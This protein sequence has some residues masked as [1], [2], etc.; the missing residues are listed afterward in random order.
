MADHSDIGALLGLSM[1]VDPDPVETRE[2]LDGLAGVL[3]REGPVRAAYLLRRLTE[4]A[5]GLGVD[6]PRAL[7]TPYVN[8][9]PLER[10]AQFPGDLSLE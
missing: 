6:A 10:Q 4:A 3:E 8:T 7:T 2:W 1:P 5:R 9:I